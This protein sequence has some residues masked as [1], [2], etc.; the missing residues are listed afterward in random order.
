[1]PGK[2]KTTNT[3]GPHECI[4]DG[5]SRRSRSIRKPGLCNTCYGRIRLGTSP[6]FPADPL[7]DYVE[8]HENNWAN[9]SAPKRGARVSLEFMDA[10][11]IDVLGVHP[12][13]VYGPLYFKECPS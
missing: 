13:V 1:V 9:R 8:S 7:I 2:A 4:A 6:L 3:N 10:F 11:C 12:W 5:C